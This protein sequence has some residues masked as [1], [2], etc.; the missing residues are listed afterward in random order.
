MKIMTSAFTGIWRFGM[1]LTNSHPQFTCFG[2]AHL[3]TVKTTRT[4]LPVATESDQQG[5]REYLVAAERQPPLS[6]LGNDLSAAKLSLNV[7]EQQPGD[8]SAQSIY[9]FAVARAVENVERA[10]IQPWQRKIHI[11]SD[12]TT[13]TL[14]TPK[15][16]D[17]EHDPSRY[18]LFPTDGLKISGQFFKTYSTESG[19]GAPLVAVARSENP[20]FRQQYKL[21]RV[22]APVTAVI[23]F[24][25]K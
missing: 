1:R 12:H 14:T 18:D 25:D 9:N 23:K 2:C 24:A 8:S 6:A 20:Q 17:P 16:I 7:L 22:Y 10:N 21:P 5:A 13:Y 15:P 4:P 3:A 19:V 11:V